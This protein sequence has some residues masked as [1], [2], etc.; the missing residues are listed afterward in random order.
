V[1]WRQNYGGPDQE[2]CQ[3]VIE[4]RPGVIY[5]VGE[6]V[7]DFSE[8]QGKRGKDYWLLR[9]EE[10]PC[11]SLQSEIFVRAP[12]FETRRDVRIRFKALHRYAQTFNWDFGDGT[13]SEEEKPLKSFSLPGNYP[14]SLTIRN[15]ESCSRT[16]RMK[17]ELK[18]R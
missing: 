8:S 2:R 5:A 10:M 11:D 17:Q 4:Y 1:I 14:I 6:K 13:H 7:N 9:I 18:V 3:A 12:D 15:N 16:V